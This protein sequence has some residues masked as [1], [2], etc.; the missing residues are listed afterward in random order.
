ML[1]AFDISWI[2]I[3]FLF[4]WGAVEWY[5]HNFFLISLVFA[6]VLDC[7]HF[8]VITNKTEHLC[9]SLCRNTCFLLGRNWVA[10]TDLGICQLSKKLHTCKLIIWSYISIVT[11]WNFGMCHLYKNVDSCHAQCF[12]F[13]SIQICAWLDLT[14]ISSVCI[15]FVINEH[16]FLVRVC[17]PYVFIGEIPA[18][19]FFYF[20]RD[21]FIWTSELERQGEK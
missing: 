2:T 14:M 8:W 10:E 16:S 1:K 5:G 7:F 20:K 19:L 13:F 15:S 18:H 12:S 3:S 6:W 11:A 4:I 17:H 9:A 21:L